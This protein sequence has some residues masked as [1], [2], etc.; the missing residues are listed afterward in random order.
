MGRA[1]VPTPALYPAFFFVLEKGSKS[2]GNAVIPTFPMHR[3]YGLQG[4]L[5]RRYK[6]PFP[7]SI[8]E[9]YTAKNG[10]G[11]IAPR[12]LSRVKV[13]THL[14]SLRKI[15]HKG[16]HAETGV[17]R[18]GVVSLPSERSARS[19]TSPGRVSERRTLPLLGLGRVC[20]RRT[21]K[22]YGTAMCLCASLSRRRRGPAG[23][24]R[25]TPPAERTVLAPI[26]PRVQLCLRRPAFPL[27][28]FIPGA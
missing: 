10:L 13:G 17:F 6:H 1:S 26:S 7:A 2:A 25:P 5:K 24:R 11:T 9:Y 28:A 15:A 8:N 20:S 4:S 14:G 18:T 27:S 3:S 19:Q 22:A 12:L 16:S 23:L 21:Q